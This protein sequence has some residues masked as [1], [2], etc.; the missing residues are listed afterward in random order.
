MCTYMYMYYINVKLL[1]YGN[2][3]DKYIY[4]LILTYNETIDCLINNRSLSL[5][6]RGQND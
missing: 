1:F 6:R 3:Q 2:K 4:E 5:K